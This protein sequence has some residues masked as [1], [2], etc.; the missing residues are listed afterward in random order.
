MRRKRGA[1]F[2]ILILALSLIAVLCRAAV[3]PEDFTGQWYASA[4]QSVY[5]FHEGIVYCAK[6]PVMLSEEAAIS[7]AYVFSRDTI[8]LFAR[9]VP[10]LERERVLYLVHG[11]ESSFLCENRNGTGPVY[12]IRYAQ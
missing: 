6:Y 3:D 10:G 1:L 5:L 8:C 12:F 2:C 9:G 11:E 4:D 7:G